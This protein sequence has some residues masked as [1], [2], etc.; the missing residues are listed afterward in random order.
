MRLW[1]STGKPM[2]HCI[3]IHR[4]EDKSFDRRGST[5]YPPSLQPRTLKRN[6]NIARPPRRTSLRKI[7]T[8]CKSYF[9][10]LYR[11]SLPLPHPSV[12]AGCSTRRNNA[13]H[14]TIQHPRVTTFWGSERSSLRDVIFGGSIQR[15]LIVYCKCQKGAKIAENPSMGEG[16]YS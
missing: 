9:A 11:E 14:E 12:D 7:S 4:N 6:K 10:L 16:V 8:P 1:R 13:L 2:L 5:N 3:W 15:T